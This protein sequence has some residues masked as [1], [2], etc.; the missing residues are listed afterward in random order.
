MTEPTPLSAN[1]SV[2]RIGVSAF[3]YGGTNGHTV[4]ESTASFIAGYCGY[5]MPRGLN[6]VT[7]NGVNGIEEDR[8]H[9]LLFSAHN[10]VTLLNNLKHFRT[11]T[12]Q[13]VLRDLAH[14]LGTRRTAHENRTF[15]VCHGSQYGAN[16]DI[17][18]ESVISMTRSNKLAFAFTGIISRLIKL[19][20]SWLMYD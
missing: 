4:L 5:M 14:T 13:K 9:L 20:L 12:K 6:A 18:A 11:A 10:K 17:A 19:C 15:V 7:E 1:N 16:F 2:H 3:G 8:A